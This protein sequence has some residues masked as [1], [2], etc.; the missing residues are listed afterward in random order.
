MFCSVD[1]ESGSD[2]P[3]EYIGNGEQRRWANQTDIKRIVERSTEIFIIIIIDRY[4][5]CSI[6][7]FNHIW[8]L[9]LF[10]NYSDGFHITPFVLTMVLYVIIIRS[11]RISDHIFECNINSIRYKFV[12]MQLIITMFLTSTC[13]FLELLPESMGK[14]F[15]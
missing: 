4:T 10:S 11:P 9:S 12:I 6:I 7:A 5:T 2:K 8:R 15:L 14:T 3:N 13:S 1:L